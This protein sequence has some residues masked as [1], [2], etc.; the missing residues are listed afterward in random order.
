MT[1]MGTRIALAPL[2]VAAACITELPLDPFAGAS[3]SGVVL[4]VAQ[5]DGE[6][7]AMIRSTSHHI[8]ENPA[9]IVVRI[10]AGAGKFREAASG[11]VVRASAAAI[12]PER[13]VTVWFD[14]EIP[15][16]QV[17]TAIQVLVY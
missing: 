3:V 14:A 15:S 7:Q 8:E 6:L 11:K 16:G 5:S 9:Q 10:P 1:S 12:V 13:P 4:S 2:L 17:V